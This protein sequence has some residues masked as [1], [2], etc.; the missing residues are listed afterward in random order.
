MNTFIAILRGINVSGQKKIRMADLKTYLE[1]AGLQNVRT[2]IQSGN[3]VFDHPGGDPDMLARLIEG[4]IRET[5][6]FD[7]PTL[8]KRAEDLVAALARNPFLADPEA[9][10][11][12]I[13]FTFL[14]EAPAA[15]K[16]D[17]LNEIEYPNESFVVD[18]LNVY[19]YVPKGYGRAKMNNNF[20]ENKL[21]VKATTRNLKT[22]KVLVEMAGFHE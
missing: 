5:Y 14:A 8:V 18:G 13:Y 16:L 1:E 12:G 3:V 6:A 9:D 7:V 19:L 20:F 17:V 2:Y 11:A 15:E 21:K 10:A 4:K 22:V